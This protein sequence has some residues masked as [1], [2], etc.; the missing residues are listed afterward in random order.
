MPIARALAGDDLSSLSVLRRSFCD[1]PIFCSTSV[2]SLSPFSMRTT[3]ALSFCTI[4]SICF[5]FIRSSERCS[6][7]SCLFSLIFSR[8]FFFF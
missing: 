8:S 6:K 3:S 2:I 4:F 5:L 7:A 1:R